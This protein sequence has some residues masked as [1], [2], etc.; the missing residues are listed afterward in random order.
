[1]INLWAIGEQGDLGVGSVKFKIKLCDMASA[2][3]VPWVHSP[4]GAAAFWGLS[5]ACWWSWWWLSRRSQHPG[6]PLVLASVGTATGYAG[7]AASHR[8]AQIQL[9]DWQ[10]KLQDRLAA[11]IPLLPFCLFT[12][13]SFLSPH[14]L[15]CQSDLFPHT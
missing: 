6:L 7:M 9:K 11:D 14:C 2:N 8:V 13:T 1:L 15:F 4:T 3:T 12:F 5:L 10:A